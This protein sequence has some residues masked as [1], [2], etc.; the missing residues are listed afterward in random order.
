MG[1]RFPLLQSLLQ[2]GSDLL[3]QHHMPTWGLQP[4][5]RLL[6]PF[7]M[8][9]DSE[10]QTVEA[11]LVTNHS[12]NMYST[13]L[14]PTEVGQK[15][16][17]LGILWIKNTSRT[18]R[19]IRTRWDTNLLVFL[20]TSCSARGF[21]VWRAVSFVIPTSSFNKPEVPTFKRNEKVQKAGSRVRWINL[22]FL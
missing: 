13:A 9:D 5:G 16:I 10:T 19:P 14:R 15:N 3:R 20:F 2:R 8:V 22:F 12:K 4:P 1:R 7:S 11:L 6:L 18:A 17:F 21:S